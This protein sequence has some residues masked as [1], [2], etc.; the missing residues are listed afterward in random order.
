[1]VRNVAIFLSAV[2]MLVFFMGGC[3]DRARD[4]EQVSKNE[5]III[6][7]SHVV[8]ESTPKGKAA[9]RFAQ[10]VH[11]RTNGRVEVQVYPNSTLYKDGEEFKALLEN[12]VQIIAPAT[13]KLT[14]MFPQWQVFDLPFIFDSYDEVHRAMDGQVGKRLFALLEQRNVLGLAMWDNGFK[15]MSATR[16][17]KSVADFKGL[18]FRI[19]PSLVLARQFELLGA[20]TKELPFNEVYGALQE[21]EVDG[22]ENPLSNFYTKK[23]HQVQSHL[24]I[25]NHGY[26]GYAVLTNKTFWNSLPEDVKRVLEETMK[27]VT[28]WERQE[29]QRLNDQVLEELKKSRE[30]NIHYLTDKEKQ[31]W[32]EALHPIYREYADIGGELLREIMEQCKEW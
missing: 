8:A 31:Q 24:T 5:R 21:G 30:I 27:E 29:A 10:L 23:F 13:A 11:E 12:N 16:P 7:F 9:K 28:R 17:L 6:R 19:M 25:S 26:L 20:E 32:Q 4:M 1:M 2:I 15:Q 14:K 3:T 22:A 18:T